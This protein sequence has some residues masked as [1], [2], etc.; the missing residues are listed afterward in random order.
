MTD[1]RHRPVASRPEERSRDRDHDLRGNRNQYRTLGWTGITV[2]PALGALM[3]G[4]SIA[5]PDHL[6]KQFLAA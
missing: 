2:S 3:L 1:S 5:D 4:A 6:C